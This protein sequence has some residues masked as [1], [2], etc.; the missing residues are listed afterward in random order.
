MLFRSTELENVD[1]K[2]VSDDVL[3]K[4]E[5]PTLGKESE[6]KEPSP[7]KSIV[8]EATIDR[9]SIIQSDIESDALKSQLDSVDGSGLSTDVKDLIRDVRSSKSP[10]PEKIDNIHTQF[11]DSH[12][13]K[14]RASIISDKFDEDS[15][16]RTKSPSIMSDKSDEKD[17]A[18]RS[19]SPS[20]TED[21]LDIGDQIL[22]SKHISELPS[23]LGSIG[24]VDSK[25]EISETSGML[26]QEKHVIDKSKS[27]SP[28]SEKSRAE[29]SLHESVDERKASI[30]SIGSH[31]DDKGKDRSRSHSLFE[32]G[33]RTPLVRS[34]AASLYEDKL[35]EKLNIAESLGHTDNI[36]EENDE[37]KLSQEAIDELQ[38]DVLKRDSI[39]ES[40]L[41]SERRK[42]IEDHIL[43]DYINQKKIITFDVV[44][45]ISEIYKI[46]RY[47]VIK[48]IN[49]LIA[50]MKLGQ[51]VINFDEKDYEES[52]QKVLD[53]EEKLKDYINDE[54]IVK[55]KKISSKMVDEIAN[56]KSVSR[57]LVL[58]VIENIITSQNL[59]RESV[60]D[61]DLVETQD[62]VHKEKESDL[63]KIQS[64]TVKD[65]ESSSRKGSVNDKNLGD[66]KEKSK[67]PEP[68]STKTSHSDRPEPRIYEEITISEN[69][70]TEVETLLIDEYIIRG[71]KLTE[72]ILEQIIIRTNLP[73][74]IILEIIDEILIKKHLSRETIADKSI[75]HDDECDETQSKLDYAESGPE[76]SERKSSGYSTPD[77][78]HYE[79]K[80]DK[81]LPYTDYESPFHKAFM[82]GMTEIRTTHITTLSGKSTPDFGHREGTPD[83][84]SETTSTTTT[85][86]SV[87]EK[88][89]KVVS[90]IS[91][92]HG[93]SVSKRQSKMDEQMQEF[94][95]SSDKS[96]YQTHSGD[97]VVILKTTQITTY[98]DEGVETTTKSSSSQKE[99]VM[100]DDLESLSQIYDSSKRSTVIETSKTII[101]GT[102]SDS[103]SLIHKLSS[104]KMSG[105]TITEKTVSV[106]TTSSGSIISSTANIEEKLISL[107]SHTSDGSRVSSALSQGIRSTVD[108]GKSTPDIKQE[109]KIQTAFTDKDLMDHTVAE[110]LE[111]SAL[112]LIRDLITDDRSYSGKSSPDV[113]LP[114][115]IAFGGSTGKSTPDISMSPLIRDSSMMQSHFSGRSTPDKRSDNRSRTDTPEGFRSGDVI[116]TIITTTRTM[117]D[118]GEIITTTKEVTEA[119]NEKGETVVLTEKTDVQVDERLP[120]SL[121]GDPK[122]VDPQRSFSPSSDVIDKEIDPTSPRS[123]LSSGHSRAATHVW[124]SS[125]ERHTYSDDEQ[126]SP[127]VSYSPHHP[128]SRLSTKEDIMKTSGDF[129]NAAMSSSFYGELPSESVH[130]SSFTKT[131]ESHSEPD[132][133]SFKKFTVEKEF[134]GA[135]SD[136]GSKKYVDEADLDFEKALTGFKDEKAA[137]GRSQETSVLEAGRFTQELSKSGQSKDSETSDSKKDPLAGWDSP[138]GLPSPKAPRKFNLRSPIQPCSSADLSPDSLNF[139][140]INDWGEPMRLPSPAPAT[141]EVSN[142]GSPGTPKKDKKQTKKVISEN[143]K[144][145]K[146]SES[147]SKNDRKTKDSKNK[148]QPVYVDLTYVSHHGNSFYTALEFFKKVR[149]RYYVF[150][151]TEPSR[152]VYDA[153]LE[154]KKTWEDKD[155]GK[156]RSVY[157]SYF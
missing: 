39:C 149:A 119:T 140:V 122:S 66:T 81:R 128:E 73:K 55:K 15:I 97:N 125:D 35:P 109:D 31:S 75:F 16:D 102:E 50:H 90:D 25:I 12:T 123:D 88:V 62:T 152:E 108:S 40:E 41:T 96:L 89:E 111:Q 36:F 64:T 114:K 121:I 144:N 19:K 85:I 20:V 94:I 124:G 53:D 18:D 82:G 58:L 37:L 98:P 86:T 92:E 27:T 32:T 69:K 129:S 60:V 79:D 151:G 22:E 67:S 132:E 63:H 154:A 57:L 139:D 150:S 76:T 34:R 135:H 147:P 38:K 115:D 91:D 99:I 127:P 43:N 72:P 26:E 48:I 30:T 44:N 153:L 24:K 49:E 156:Y 141:N 10:S 146:R 74:Y 68:D 4:S 136:K 51:D 116:R 110:Q 42:I 7:E 11:R 21:R 47:L 120:E 28:V 106:T 113:S 59:I 104:E 33:D 13:D 103:S 83:F 131:T 17:P 84:T 105:P 2:T 137:P 23:I 3:G 126:S 117:S 45:K 93:H 142:K 65:K 70:R 54:F 8:S 112:P 29:T 107:E 77:T 6:K 118:D 52:A 1:S 78:R 56:C 143:M 100:K 148:V 46:D 5:T 157:R 80:L 61:T 130:F 145:K 9:T 138:L 101:S 155:L 134:S 71:T 133:F 95:K 14:P 87:P